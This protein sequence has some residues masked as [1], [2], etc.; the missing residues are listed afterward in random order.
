V[1]GGTVVEVHDLL[2]VIW[3]SLVAGIG[4]VTAGSLAIYGAA[5][6]NSERRDGHALA[7]TA[8]G[9]LAALGALVCT[10]GVIVG[11]SVM[12]SKG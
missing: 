12:L 3:V 7:A 2:E 10:A 11:V 5:R 6:A 1:I 9:T 8:Y 4:L